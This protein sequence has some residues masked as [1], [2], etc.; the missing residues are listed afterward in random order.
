MAQKQF[1]EPQRGLKN[2]FRLSDINEMLFPLPPLEEQKRIVTKVKF[3]M[4]LCDTLESQLTETRSIAE[5]LA[6]SAVAAIT[7]NQMENKEKMK[8]PKTELVTCLRLIKSP[9]I[10]TQAPLCAILAKQNSELSAKTL[11]N[12]SGLTIDDFYRQL[13]TEMANGWIVEPQKAE[14]RIVEEK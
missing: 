4:A 10:K 9:S 6:Q 14:M 8:A 3:L 12:Y 11:W 2:S 7:G 13:K 5:K 1:S